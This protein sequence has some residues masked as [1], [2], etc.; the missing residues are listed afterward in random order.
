MSAFEMI[1]THLDQ[2]VPFARHTGVVLKSVADGSAVAEL[3]E[4]PHTLNHIATQHAGA[5]YTLGEAASGGAMAGALVDRLMTVRPVA[6]EARIKYLAI[7]RGTIAA[8]A[9]TVQPA[10]ALRAEL[11]AIGKI[12]F[13]VAVSL[14]DASGKVVAEM[15]V[16][17]HVKKLG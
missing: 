14:T 17:W 7:A 1:R 6:A 4:Q 5:L 13:D 11:D 3:P 16:A 8:T 9:D 15:T 2:A 10:A 12:Q